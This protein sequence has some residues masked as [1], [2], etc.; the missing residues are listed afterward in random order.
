M[1]FIRK[2]KNKIIVVCISATAFIT[3]LVLWLQNKT[4]ESG[5][6][7]ACNVYPLKFNLADTLFYVDHSKLSAIKEWNFGDGNISVN[8]SGYYIYN[9]P[10]YYQVTLKLNGKYSRSFP[11]EVIDNR[12]QGTLEDSITTID[13]PTQGMQYENLVFRAKSATAKMYSWSLGESGTVDSKEA[14]VIYAYQ[15]PGEYTITLNTDEMAYP[16]TKRIRILPSFK[17][18]NDSSTVED[19]YEKIDNDFKEHLQL[20]ATGKDFNTHYNYLLEKYLCKNEN[21]IVKVNTTKAN[22]FYYYCAGLQFDKNITIQT[23]KVSFDAEQNCVVKVEV[24][25]SKS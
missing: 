8:D 22:S 1:S 10:G 25:Q 5:G 6:N 18:V 3:A 4:N 2:N 11:V 20:I 17:V 23:V 14:L 13:G 21:A 7:I 12:I 9:K 16:I 24:S 19:L 15:H